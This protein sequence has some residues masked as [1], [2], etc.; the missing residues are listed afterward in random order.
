MSEERQ[1]FSPR[2]LRCS[3][4][5][6]ITIFVIS[7]VVYLTFIG[8]VYTTNCIIDFNIF[9]VLHNAIEIFETFM[10]LLFLIGK[11]FHFELPPALFVVCLELGLEM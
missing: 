3:T 5:A 7:K 4:T 10:F 9:L 1:S 6:I 8:E 11:I 2:F